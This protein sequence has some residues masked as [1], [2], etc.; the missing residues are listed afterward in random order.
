MG[1]NFLWV[2]ANFSWVGVGCVGG[3]ERFMGGCGLVWVGVGR[4][5]K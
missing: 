1:V 3:S 2:G 4:S 5:A